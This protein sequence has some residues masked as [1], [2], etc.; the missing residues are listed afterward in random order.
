ATI[1]PTSTGDQLAIAVA[2]LSFLHQVAL[3]PVASPDAVAEALDA[4]AIDCSPRRDLSINPAKMLAIALA[5]ANPLVWGGTVLAARAARRVAESI[6]RTSGRTALAGDA[7]HL[8]PVIEA[9][10]PR[11]VFDDPFADEEGDL[12]PVLL[13]LDDGADEPVVIEQRARL[14]EA[15][16][17]HGV[18]VE[19][20]STEADGDVARYASLLLSGTYAAEYL[21]LGLVND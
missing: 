14:E 11:T 7:E 15:A 8:L 20:V 16:G 2:M 4:V 19:T 13:I 12:R 6:R 21:R 1:L 5:D 10:R 17:T 9:A 18:R 3:G